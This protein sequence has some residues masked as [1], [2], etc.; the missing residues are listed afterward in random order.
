MSQVQTNLT[1]KVAAVETAGRELI[2]SALQRNPITALAADVITPIA[3][4]FR[5]R[6]GKSDAAVRKMKLESYSYSP[7]EPRSKR[8]R[9]PIE[10]SSKLLR[11]FPEA[12]SVKVSKKGGLHHG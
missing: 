6:R 11:T 2:D 5:G 7:V 4:L 9:R 12:S 8:K 1:N 10:A 3:K